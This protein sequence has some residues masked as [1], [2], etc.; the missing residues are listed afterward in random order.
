M[1]ITGTRSYILVEFDHRTVKIAGEMVTNLM[2][3][4]E[5]RT[6]KN[7]EAPYDHIVIEEDEKLQIMNAVNEEIKDK[8][9]KIIFE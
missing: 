9:I 7:W 8:E 4:A 2:F 3:Y 6:M 1:K 5:I